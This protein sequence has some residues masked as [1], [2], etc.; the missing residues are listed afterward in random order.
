MQV[1]PSDDPHEAFARICNDSRLGRKSILVLAG[2]DPRQ[3]GERL[4]DAM[5]RFAPE[6]VCWE[7]V[8]GANPP[9]QPV[10]GTLGSA[11]DHAIEPTPT[12]RPEPRPAHD[13]APALRLA[14]APAQA[15]RASGNVSSKDVL[16]ADELDALLA[17]E[18]PKKH[19][20]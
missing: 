18:M 12:S 2:E 19:G 6:A 17:G 4:M 10:V 9:I 1:V 7:H 20:D 5:E 13:P 14:P 8:P 11:I 3:L 16:N 15:P